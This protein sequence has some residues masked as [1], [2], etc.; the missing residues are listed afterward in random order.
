MSKKLL[1]NLKKLILQT[2]IKQYLDNT[3]P[4]L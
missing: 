4:N 3:I 1:K 2:N